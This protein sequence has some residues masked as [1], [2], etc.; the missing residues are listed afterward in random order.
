[1]PPLPALAL[2]SG[3][4]SLKFGFYRVGSSRTELLLSGEA[5]AKDESLQEA[6]AAAMRVHGSK[7]CGAVHGDRVTCSGTRDDGRLTP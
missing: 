3:S 5:E 4:S 6:M 2:N 7:R 1:M